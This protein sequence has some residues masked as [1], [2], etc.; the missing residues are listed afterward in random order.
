L[1]GQQQAALNL[2]ARP[3]PLWAAASAL[4]FFPAAVALSELPTYLSYL[5]PRLENN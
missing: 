1:F 2:V 4:V 3:L 5:Q